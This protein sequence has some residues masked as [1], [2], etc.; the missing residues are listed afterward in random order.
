MSGSPPIATVEPTSRFGSFGPIADIPRLIDSSH[1]HMPASPQP[2][3]ELGEVADFAID[4]DPARRA[5]EL[6]ARSLSTGQGHTSAELAR[7]NLQCRAK[8]SLPLAATPNRKLL[9]S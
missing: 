3:R 1:H 5:V 7:C 4:S 6:R 2:H 8:S 9:I